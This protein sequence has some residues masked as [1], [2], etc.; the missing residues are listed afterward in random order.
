MASVT[1]NVDI[2]PVGADLTQY[3]MSLR[4]IRGLE[5]V[6]RV[7]YQLGSGVQ[8]SRGDWA[9]LDDS[10]LLQAPGSNGVVNTYLVFSGTNAF[11]SYATGGATVFGKY[12]LLCE[13]NNFDTGPTYHAGSP[14]TYKMVSSVPKLTLAGSGDAILA[15]VVNVSNG[16]MT[17]EAVTAPI[18]A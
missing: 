18:K 10:G 6:P 3:D 8:V 13:T 15:S 5:R 11:D 4:V 16:L 9:V 2:V 17:F 14:L 1:S 7:D 12:P